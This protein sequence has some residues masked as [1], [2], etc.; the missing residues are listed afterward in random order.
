[1]T[2][3][4]RLPAIVALL[5]LVAV[6]LTA[7][8][9]T[10]IVLANVPVDLGAIDPSLPARAADATWIDAGLWYAAALFFLISSIRLMRRT[11]GFWTWL[12]GFAFYG[13]RWALAQ[14]GDVAAKLQALDLQSY[15][16]PAALAQ[17]GDSTEAQ[18]AILGIV[19]I[20]GVVIFVIDFADRAYWNRQGA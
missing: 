9:A 15:R 7:A 8:I 20:V 18:I 16:D 5:L 12:L 17:A 10:T 4:L 1:M 19:L 3:I 11:Q 6:S 14:Q 13:G 2:F